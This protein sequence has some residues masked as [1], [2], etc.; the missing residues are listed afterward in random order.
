MRTINYIFFWSI[1]TIG[2]IG[3]LTVIYGYM[4][5]SLTHVSPVVT[6]FCVLFFTL[7]P[8]LTLW[9]EERQGV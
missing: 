9:S 2:V 1:W 7:S 4:N 8:I 5:K 3:N 6:A